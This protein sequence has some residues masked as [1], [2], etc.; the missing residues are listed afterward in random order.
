M[1]LPDGF[2]GT[3]LPSLSLAIMDEDLNTYG[4]EQEANLQQ[5]LL[6]YKINNIYN[7]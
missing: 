1:Y 4:I 6:V 3:I 5:N 2:Q 7:Y